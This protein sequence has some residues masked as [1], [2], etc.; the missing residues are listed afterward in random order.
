MYVQNFICKCLS[1]CLF[2]LFVCLKN[3]AKEPGAITL[4]CLLVNPF[5]PKVIISKEKKRGNF[6]VTSVVEN[7]VG[8]A[9]SLQ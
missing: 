9:V 8:W 6:I 4:I 1:V 3:L 5:N 2:V 7:G